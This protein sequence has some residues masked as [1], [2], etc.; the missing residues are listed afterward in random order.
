LN[1]VVELIDTSLNKFFELP[2]VLSLGGVIMMS[3]SMVIV[4]HRFECIE[5]M[6]VVEICIFTKSLTDATMQDGGIRERSDDLDLCDVIS[7]LLFKSKIKKSKNKIKQNKT[8]F[9]I[10]NFD[11]KL[12]CVRIVM[13]TEVLLD[14]VRVLIRSQKVEASEVLEVSL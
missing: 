10:H 5:L 4:G 14:V 13:D 2:G 3:S 6:E 7:Y 1:E 8:K 11:K 12:I 9:I